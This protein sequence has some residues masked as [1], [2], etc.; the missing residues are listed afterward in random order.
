LT[1]SNATVQR[2]PSRRNA[3]V[4]QFGDTLSWTRG[5]H[6]LNFGFTFTQVN[7]WSSAVADGVV[8]N[9]TF[10]L[11][12]ADPAQAIFTNANFNT[13]GDPKNAPT[14]A[15]LNQARALYAVLAGRVTSVSGQLALD[16]NTSQYALNSNLVQRARQ[17]ESGYFAQDTWRF[18]PNLTLTGGLR[19]EV[20]YPFIAKNNNFTQTTLAGLFGVSGEGNFFKPGVTPGSVTQFTQFKPGD[21][22][23]KPKYNNFAP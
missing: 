17:R 22:A 14:T 20:Q 8:R 1:L 6:N 12:T 15:Q 13:T 7:F 4:W 10:T 3:P 16:E 9:V 18:R 2:G 23:Y 11:A 5:S 21:E 19:W